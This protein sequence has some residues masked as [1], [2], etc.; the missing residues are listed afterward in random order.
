MSRAD[1][2]V[3]FPDTPKHASWMNPIGVWFGILI[4]KGIKRGQNDE[5]LRHLQNKVNA[6]SVRPSCRRLA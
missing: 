1:H 5:E 3:V 4:K 2:N 6:F